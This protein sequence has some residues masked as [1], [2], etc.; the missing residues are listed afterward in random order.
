MW[1]VV[2]KTKAITIYYNDYWYIYIIYWYSKI[3]MI[4]CNIRMTHTLTSSMT[5]LQSFEK[6]GAAEP[7]WNP[8]GAVRPTPT[9]GFATAN[10]KKPNASLFSWLVKK[11]SEADQFDQFEFL[12][13]K[14][15]HLF[16]RWCIRFDPPKDD[17]LI[18]KSGYGGI[19]WNMSS[20]PSMAELPSHQ[21]NEVSKG[22]S[23]NA[24][25]L[26]AVYWRRNQWHPMTT[27]WCPLVHKLV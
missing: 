23:S 17:H 7:S 9:P 2:V 16:I 14:F 5:H 22:V 27:K 25:Q 4:L 21:N 8:P 3:P 20:F 15:D 12:V 24:S 10:L 18:T 19:L 13:M 11:Q 26:S 1:S 6:P